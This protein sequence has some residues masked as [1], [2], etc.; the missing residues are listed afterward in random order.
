M[1]NP[2]RFVFTITPGHTGTTWLAE[3]LGAHLPRCAA[4]HERLGFDLFGEQTPDLS[5]LTRFNS[6]GN[7]AAVRAFWRRKAGHVM[8]E[9]VS[10]YIE[11]SHLLAKCGLLENLELFLQHGAVTILCVARD[12]VAI[13]RSMRRRGDML[14]KGDQWLWHLDPDYPRKLLDAG[15]FR[16]HGYDGLRA[17]YV[18]EMAARAAYYRRLLE[19][20]PG[21]RFVSVRIEDLREAPGARALL[22]TL[23]VAETVAPDLPPKRNTSPAWGDDRAADERVQALFTELNFDAERVAAEYFE[24][25]YRLGTAA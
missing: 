12:P 6:E 23:G 10:T 19:D 24:R 7:V 3:F 1:A 17:W 20:T 5:H 25:G 16:P 15:F 18:C 8:T 11:T 9:S 14:N 13:V 4:Y 2:P 21:V 22:T